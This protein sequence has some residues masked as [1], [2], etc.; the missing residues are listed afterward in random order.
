MAHG[1]AGHEVMVHEPPPE[2]AAAYRRAFD[3]A[4]PA[5][6]GAVVRVDLEA[7]EA[8]WRFTPGRA[9][10][11]WTFNGQVPGPVIEARVGDVLEV[12]LTNRLT[13]PTTLHWHG[14]RLPAPMD[15]TDMVQRPVEPGETF[16]YRIALLDAGTFWYH[17]HSNEATQVRRGMYGA[18]IVRG[19]NEPVLD[20]E[21]VLVL[22]DASVEAT[23]ELS[24]TVPREGRNGNVRLVNGAPEPE[25]MM[26][27][28]QV[29]RWRVINASS[30]RY[31]RL[32]IG[33]QP[34][35]A[36]GTGGGLLEAPVQRR[37]VLLTPGDRIDIAVGPFE[38]GAV[39]SVVSEPYDRGFGAGEA[40][41]FAT[42]L[43]GPAA[44]SQAAVPER[45]RVI[46][47]LVEGPVVPTR[48]VRFSERADMHGEVDFLI[49]GNQHHRADP[50]V[51][52]ELQVW[53]IVNTSRL[54]HP[55][56]LHGFFF[57]V[58]ERDGAP[59][60]FRSW[61]DTVNVPAGGRVRIAWMPDDRLGEWMYHCHILEHHAAGMMA[62][63]A[64]VRPTHEHG[65]A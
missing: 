52:G 43:V 39:V 38:P 49:N 58:L 30:A 27:G 45:L 46:T 24:T 20:R 62:H 36:L 2:A 19:P 33:G 8:D 3:D 18:L 28:G 10:R 64:V 56:H 17:S 5:P 16:V 47:P 50:I 42:L 35:M 51:V 12:S 63:F 15:G 26:W 31:V 61:E 55:F 4:R 32:L 25:L 53:D 22:S 65:Q 44:P 41:R 34:F 60:A 29:E 59:P 6:G 48:E 11:A 14:L 1:H 23:G 54:D 13:E 57:Q 21:R 7:R 37:D 9:V 40:E